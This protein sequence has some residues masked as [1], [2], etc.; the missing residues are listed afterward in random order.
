MKQVRRLQ[1]F[2][3]C[4]QPVAHSRCSNRKRKFCRRFIDV[5]T[6]GWACHAMRRIVLIDLEFRQLVSGP[7]CIPAC[8]P[9]A[10]CEPAITTCTGSSC[11]L[12][13]SPTVGELV[14]NRRTAKIQNDMGCCVQDS[15]EWYQCVSWKTGQHVLDRTSSVARVAVTS[16]PSCQRMAPKC[17]IFVCHLLDFLEQNEDNIG[18]RT[19]NPDGLP[20]QPD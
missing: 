19:H 5:S 3:L 7:R 15:L 6:A 17:H 20:P 13:T 4:Q 11:Q 9:K 16:R 18:R 1:Q 14:L 2:Q 12:V 8:V 10:A